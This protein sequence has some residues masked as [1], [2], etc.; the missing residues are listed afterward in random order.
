[1]GPSINYNHRHKAGDFITSTD[2]QIT[3]GDVRNAIAHLSDDAEVFLGACDCGCILELS[4]FKD[5]T[6]AIS[7]NIRCRE[8]D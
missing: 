4:G 5:R 1:M 8:L 7:F 6:G 3:V 2:G